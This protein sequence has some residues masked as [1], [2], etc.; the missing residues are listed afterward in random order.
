[1][2]A[3]TFSKGANF[4]V[5]LFLEMNS[6]PYYTH[7]LDVSAATTM[8]LATANLYSRIN[9]EN[10]SI[11]LKDVLL[12]Y[13]LPA[14]TASTDLAALYCQVVL[15]NIPAVNYTDISNNRTILKTIHDTDLTST[16]T[17]NR[18]ILAG[19]DDINTE[20]IVPRQFLANNGYALTV[21]FVITS[22]VAT[23]TIVAKEITLEI[24][25]VPD[26]GNP[27]YKHAE[28]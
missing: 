2:G 20:F 4:F 19:K 17:T 9:T 8:R 22:P 5:S 25:E 15:D 13:S 28:A 10:V 24:R 16:T 1:L 26:E 11:K 6:K 12:M 7:A 3:R 14:F 23:A 27:R 21:S 18:R